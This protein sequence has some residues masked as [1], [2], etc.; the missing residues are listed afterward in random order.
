MKN[1]L[2]KL[3]FIANIVFVA[4]SAIILFLMFEMGKISNMQKIERDHAEL[5][6]LLVARTFEVKLESASEGGVSGVFNRNH[7][8]TLEGGVLQILAAMQTKPEEVLDMTNEFEKWM[9]GVMGF[10]RAFELAHED[11][12]DIDKV[13]KNIGAYNNGTISVVKCIELNEKL[14]GKLQ[15]NGV[16]FADIVIDAAGLVKNMMFYGTLIMLSSFSVQLFRGSNKIVNAITRISNHLQRVAKGD[17]SKELEVQQ[18]NELGLI[19]KFSNKLTNE[20]NV[21]M[22]DVNRI[23]KE[24]DDVSNTFSTVAKDLNERAAN[25]ASAAQEISASLQEL[26]SNTEMNSTRAQ[27]TNRIAE[28]VSTEIKKVSAFSK[29]S[30]KSVEAIVE[31]TEAINE[32]ASQTNMLALNAAVEAARAGEHGK[33]FA[34]VAKEVQQL[35]EKSKESAEDITD[36]AEVT[37]MLEKDSGEKTEAILPSIEKTSELVK[38]ITKAS[39]E[40]KSS[41][42]LVSQFAQNLNN[43]TQQNSEA[44]Q[45]MASQS[46]NLVNQTKKLQK[47][48]SFFKLA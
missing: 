14:I 4:F 12:E 42:E 34:V 46:E 39:I 30:L 41:T 16:E 9:F 32:I 23:I 35:A 2:K 25:Q 7:R 43:I 11:I 17:I 3:A 45:A 33:G 24:L 20:L 5:T 48:M 6:Q 13:R 10:E 47:R 15:K 44:S 28:E 27:E 26:A 40:Q 37:L 19:T 21:V 29:N 18:D 8:E 36:L 38:G 22:A 1:S 31:K